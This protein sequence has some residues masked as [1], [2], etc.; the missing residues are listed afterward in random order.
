MA[1]KRLTPEQ[2]RAFLADPE[3]FWSDDELCLM[4]GI[5]NE[6]DTVEYNGRIFCG[7][8][9]CNKYGRILG[10]AQQRDAV[11]A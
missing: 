4:C 1:Q 9:C 2:A 5:E 8:R 3:N 6:W 11:E 7:E 10:I